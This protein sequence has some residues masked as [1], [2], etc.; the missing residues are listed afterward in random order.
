MSV[1]EE[2]SCV[3]HI[4]FCIFVLNILLSSVFYYLRKNNYPNP[5]FSPH[6]TKLSK[7][8]FP[9]MCNALMYNNFL[10]QQFKRVAMYHFTAYKKVV[11]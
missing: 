5:I 11:H 4:Y 8:I 9:S 10:L 3:K 2:H 7:Y 1:E 6:C